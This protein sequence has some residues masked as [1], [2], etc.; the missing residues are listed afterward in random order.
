MGYSSLATV[1]IWSPYS[2]SRGGHQIDSVAIHCMAGNLSAKG[3]GELFLSPTNVASSNYGVGSDGTIG[4][5]VDEDNRS[6]CTSSTGVDSRAIAIEVA[7]TQAS[8]PWPVSDQAYEALI[9]LLVDICRRHPGLRV[10]FAG[11]LISSTDSMQQP[12]DQLLSRICSLI[13]G[14]HRKHVPVIIST[15]D[16]ER[17]QMKSIDALSSTFQYKE[18][19][20]LER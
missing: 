6:I 9:N 11:K 4:V 16:S 1:K 2:R 3:C 8:E 7:N 14:F 15:S 13:D 12:V 10:D 19:Y 20:H 18:P 5:Y 17:L